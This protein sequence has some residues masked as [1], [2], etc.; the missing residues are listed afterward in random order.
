MATSWIT[1]PGVVTMGYG[2]ASG[3][4]SP[5]FPGG[6]IRA[7]LPYFRARGV[8]ISPYYPGTLNIDI[9]PRRFAMVRP[10]HALTDVSWRSGV[11]AETFSFSPCRLILPA[12]PVDGLV[13]HPH[14]ETKPEHHQPPTV[15]EILAPFIEGVGP[16]TAVE[17]QLDSSE[18]DVRG[19]GD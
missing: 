9:A 15:L 10:S 16:G 4:G 5:R 2:V 11:P 17:L 3:S 18:V 8:D 19:E 12:G 1:I 7:Q 13:Y 6:T 14:P